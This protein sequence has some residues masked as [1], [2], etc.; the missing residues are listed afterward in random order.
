MTKLLVETKGDIM[1]WDFST[2]TEVHAD[3]PTVVP[4]SNF[5]HRNATCGN[6]KVLATD[7]P[8]TA[9]D[10]EFAE[11]WAVEADIAV[12]AYLSQFELQDDDPRQTEKSPEGK[13]VAAAK[14]AAKAAKAPKG[15]KPAP[16]PAKPAE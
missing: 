8:D 9:T 1:L 15:K 13:E 5:I 10:D 16:A 6:L 11:Y 7:L 2:R 12:D 4:V 14:A 3:R